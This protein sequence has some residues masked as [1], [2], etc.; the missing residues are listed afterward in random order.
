MI[1]GNGR[2]VITNSILDLDQLLPLPLS[3]T[4][5]RTRVLIAAYKAAD[6]EVMREKSARQCRVDE[7]KTAGTDT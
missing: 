4:T 2:D 6:S 7:Q 1:A 3:Q 5:T